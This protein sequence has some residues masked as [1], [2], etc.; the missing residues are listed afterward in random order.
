MNAQL[1]GVRPGIHGF[2][3][4]TCGDV[5]ADDVTSAGG[6]FTNPEGDEIKHGLPNDFLRHWGDMGNINGRRDGF[7]RIFK[8]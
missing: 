1:H 5:R 2:H 3:I 6:H 7:W 4:H 8:C